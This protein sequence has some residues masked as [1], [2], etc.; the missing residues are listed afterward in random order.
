MDY[1]DFDPSQLEDGRSA[2]PWLSGHAAQGQGGFDSS[3][4]VQVGPDYVPSTRYGQYDPESIDFRHPPPPQPPIPHSQPINPEYQGQYLLQQQVQQQTAH[5]VP[6][7]RYTGC[8]RNVMVDGRTRELSEYCSLEH[9]RNDIQHG[10]SLC[11]ACQRYPRRATSFYCGS[12]CE[13]AA[14][15]Q[16]PRQQEAN[17]Q[18][19]QQQQLPQLPQLRLQ[20]QQQEQQRLQQEREQQ[21]ELQR[22]Q[23]QQQ[24]ELQ[25]LR[26][27]Q[28]QELQRTQRQQRQELQRQQQ[29]QQQQ[30]ELQRLQQQQEHELQ[31]LQQ[32]QQQEQQ[33]LQQQQQQERQRLLDQL[34]RQQWR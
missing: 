15:R 16:R 21:Q 18:Q 32:Q 4:S 26:E 22:L 1:S 29:Q 5:H 19:Q 23:W 30:R 33:R 34:Q 25:R 20:Q 24:R 8:N 9:M 12:S 28:Q 31:R 11:L 13:W 27:Q 14:Q 2:N 6:M 17:Q 10:V 3:G 7:C